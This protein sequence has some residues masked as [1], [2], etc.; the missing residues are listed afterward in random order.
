MSER[1]ERA[2]FSAGTLP[3]LKAWVSRT[4]GVACFAGGVFAAVGA[5]QQ[6]SAALVS[7][8][9]L[10]IVVGALLCALP[11]FVRYVAAVRFSPPLPEKTE[12]AI[13]Q[14]YRDIAETR[15]LLRGIA[16]EVSSLQMEGSAGGFDPAWIGEVETELA[17]LRLDMEES[18]ARLAALIPEEGE[19]GKPLPEGLLAK[20]LGRAGR[21]SRSLPG[22]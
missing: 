17:R 6:S 1:F 8:A 13:A 4:G 2:T 3:P 19:E 5:W 11:D 15:E 20:A 14:A 16:E 18:S 12:E 9:C 7:V 21:G 22:G 10:C